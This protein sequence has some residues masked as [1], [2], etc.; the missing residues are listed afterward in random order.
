M[1]E[2]RDERGLRYFT[3]DNTADKLYIRS[4]NVSD[5]DE[6]LD[7]VQEH[8][9]PDISLCDI[10]IEAEH[11]QTECLGY[12]IHDPHDYSDYLVLSRKEG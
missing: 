4:G 9:G 11:I 1:G 2:Y 5:L 7:R 12:D 3:P 8:F 6:L 10:E